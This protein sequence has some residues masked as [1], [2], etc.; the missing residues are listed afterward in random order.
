MFNKFTE[1]ARKVILLAKQEAKRF[2]HDYIGTEHVLLGLLRE[3]EGVA[4]AVLQSL[5]MNL[6][7]IRLEVEKLVQLGPATVVSGDLPFTP[8]A[9]KVMELA[10]EEARTLGH[11]YIG[12]E[13][14]LLGLIRE[15]E[16]VAS[17]VF[18]NMGLDLEKVREEVIKLLGSTTPGAQGLA[19]GQGQQQGQGPG[20]G[21]SSVSKTKTPALDAF[22]RDLTRLAKESKLDPVIGRDEEIERVMQTLSRRRKNNPVLLGE[23]GIGKSAIVEGLAQK[24]VSGDVPEILKNKRVITLDLALMVAG[25]KYRGQFEER[26]KAVMD[27]IKRSENIILF[28]D[29]LHTLVGAGGAEGA[30]DA[31]NILKPAL[32]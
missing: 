29:E 10:M 4:A 26:I 18:A 15:G 27:E 24:V 21:S 22:G 5:G 9:K 25:T 28:V 14:L 6:N 1:R 3:G 2:N 20:Q 12:T 16:G 13:H 30:I 17:Q 7:N 32:A 23:A 19:G 11:N 31:A 8:K